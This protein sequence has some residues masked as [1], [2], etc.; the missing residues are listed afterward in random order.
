MAFCEPGAALG[1]CVV[2]RSA[3]TVR[4][5]A[6]RRLSPS[7]FR[8]FWLPFGGPSSDNSRAGMPWGSRDA[9]LCR[10]SVADLDLVRLLWSL[11]FLVTRFG[12]PLGEG[13]VDLITPLRNFLKIFRAAS[14]H[15]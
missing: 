8:V 2:R 5:G 4:S 7:P 13:E 6:P 9:F 11:F 10:C 3:R 12:D 1:G 15:L 14:C